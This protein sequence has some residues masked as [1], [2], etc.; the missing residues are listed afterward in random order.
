MGDPVNQMFGSQVILTTDMIR[1]WQDDIQKAERVKADADATIADRR[2]K[3]DAAAILGGTVSPIPPAPEDD[4][5]SMQAAMERI[6]L[7]FN[8]SVEHH[9]ILVELRKIPRFAESLERH[10][11][12]YFYTCIGRLKK[13]GKI[14][15][16]G[17][18]KVRFIHK[19]ETPPEET[20]EGAS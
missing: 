10:K 3:L 18:G 2:R 17:R 11:A 14:K 19:I 1:Q 7:G 20:P 9:E 4:G 12:A 5:E 15:K 8:R 16:V 6:G 13:D